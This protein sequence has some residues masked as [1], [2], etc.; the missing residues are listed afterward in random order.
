MLG[1]S[2]HLRILLVSHTCRE[3]DSVIRI[4]SARQA[5]ARERQHYTRKKP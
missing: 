4:I 1:L 5:T 2:C 3:D